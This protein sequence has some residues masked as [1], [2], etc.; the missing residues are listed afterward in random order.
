MAERASIFEKPRLGL[1]STPGTPVAAN[2]VLRSLTIQPTPVIPR[3]PIRASGNMAATGMTSG[4]EHTTFTVEGPLTYTDSAFLF[5]SVLGAPISNTA[6]G[7]TTLTWLPNAEAANTL[8]TYTVEVGS[9]N[10]SAGFAGAFLTDL[11]ISIDKDNANVSGS[12]LGRVFQEGI[13]L[14]SSTTDVALEPVSSNQVS[15]FVASTLAALDEPE[16]RMKRCLSANFGLQGR[17][18]PIFTLDDTEQSFSASVERFYDKTAQ[19]VV[20]QDSQGNG[21]MGSLKRNDVF[22]VRYIARGREITTGQRLELHVTFPCQ[23]SSTSRGDQDDIYAGTYDLMSI[24]QSNAFGSGK[25]GYVEVVL[26]TIAATATQ[27]STNGSAPSGGSGVK[28]AEDVTAY[29]E[30]A[31]EAETEP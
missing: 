31:T 22:F 28:A 12:G 24:F 3:N 9:G 25:H 20:E 26:K 1:E 14:T 27:A 4:K 13:T 17:Q 30:L 11:S 23:I 19:I 6:S 10:G 18:T 15:V 29:D 7:V 5:N 2:L 8:R 21:L 16:A